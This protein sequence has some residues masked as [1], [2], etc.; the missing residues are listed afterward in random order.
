MLDPLSTAGSVAGIISL[1]I[2]VCDG[3]V[4]YL[5]SVRGRKK[6]I[7]DALREAETLV[8]IFYSLHG[9]LS[10]LPPEISVTSIQKCLKDSEEQLLAMQKWLIDLR[11][12]S[13]TTSL[14]GKVEEV[15]RSVVYPFRQVKLDALRQTLRQL[16]DG[17]RM[18]VGV[19]AVSLAVR[20]GNRLNKIETAVETLEEVSPQLIGGTIQELHDKLDSLQQRFSDAYRLFEERFDRL[21]WNVTLVHADTRAIASDT[22]LIASRTKQT[23]EEVKKLRE[24]IEEFKQQILRAPPQS[25]STGLD[26]FTPRTGQL[27][28]SSDVF[29]LETS[30][31]CPAV[32]CNISSTYLRIGGLVFQYDEEVGQKHQRGCKL[33]GIPQP[34][35]RR[36]KAEMS[37][38]M[39]WLL[40]RVLTASVDFATGGG[41]LGVSVGL[42][43]FVPRH[44]DPVR[45]LLAKNL[46]QLYRNPS[47]EASIQLLKAS[48]RG[49]LSLYQEGRA[50][51][52]DRDEE[53]VGH[54]EVSCHPPYLIHPPN[55]SRLY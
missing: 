55:S 26:S 51:P 15:G 42:K 46:Y 43:S 36:L 18:S 52:L 1:G 50:S 48:E 32:N 31:T 11:G 20:S 28:A 53:G 37:L 38:P 21:D 27:V 14:K 10:R 9:L 25:Q 41:G 2:Q 44:L 35:N 5:R 24:G 13:D 23:A 29:S 49:I 30:C 19:A 4:S 54:A 12:S 7:A 17:L 22:A 8:P 33:Y 3:L 34:T 39:T 40:R 47:P 6:D 16:L 45:L